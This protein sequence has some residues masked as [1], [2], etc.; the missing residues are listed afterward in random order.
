LKIALE[1]AF[2]VK[3]ILQRQKNFRVQYLLEYHTM[4]C[5][6]GFSRKGKFNLVSAVGA[7]PGRR[8]AI[9]RVI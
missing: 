5:V 2:V 8:H 9:S 7:L 4:C 6:A 1:P 3:G